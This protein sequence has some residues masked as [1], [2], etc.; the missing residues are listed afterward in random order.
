MVLNIF[1]VRFRAFQTK[2]KKEKNKEDFI[3]CLFKANVPLKM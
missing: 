3:F 2:I 1:Y